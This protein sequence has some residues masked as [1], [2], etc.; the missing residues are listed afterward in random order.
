MQGRFP[1]VGTVVH[2]D[3]ALGEGRRQSI[4]CPPLLCEFEVITIM[5]L[6]QLLGSTCSLPLYLKGFKVHLETHQP[7]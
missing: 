3:R 4:P 6:P 2:I 1:S 5:C 7:P